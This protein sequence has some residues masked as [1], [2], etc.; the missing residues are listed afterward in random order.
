MRDYAV[1]HLDRHVA[2]VRG[3]RAAGLNQVKALPEDL[4]G[5]FRKLNGLTGMRA[6]EMLTRRLE[7]L[8]AAE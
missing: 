7:A 2:T 3:V 8:K 1:M 5:L 6:E 4:P